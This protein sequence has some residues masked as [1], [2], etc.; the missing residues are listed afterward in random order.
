MTTLSLAACEQAALEAVSA[1]EEL[2]AGPVDRTVVAAKGS[3]RELVTGLDLQLE[4]LLTERLSATGIAVVGEES[5]GPQ[6]S[7][8]PAGETWLVDPID[9]TVNFA[10]GL[11]Y[12]GVSVGLFSQGRFAAGAVSLPA[13]KELYFTYGA[14]SPAGT[15]AF[16][17]GR[18][19]R[20]EPSRLDD[21]LVGASF[22]SRGPAQL[23]TLFGKVNERTRGVV[24]L[25]SAAAMICQVACGRLQAVY[26]FSAKAWD[27]AGGLAVARAA[28]CELWFELKTGRAGLPELDYV[29]AAPGV[30]E[31]LRR[32]LQEGSGSQG[33]LSGG[34]R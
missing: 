31:P 1:A 14:G 25:G 32:L 22:P 33:D 4:K 15:S 34:A 3:R 23:Y 29:V 30:G 28:G 27:V 21:A 20:A 5:F 7:F 10:S 17:G 16:L 19:L 18:R 8:D 12:Y 13:F 2:L 9:G 26:G 11:P 24:R 6:S